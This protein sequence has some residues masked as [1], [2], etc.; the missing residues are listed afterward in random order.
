MFS[1]TNF[2]RNAGDAG[3][4]GGG[5]VLKPEG[6]KPAGGD[7]LDAL[8]ESW[9][10]EI[11]RLRI[12]AADKRIKLTQFEAAQADAERKRQEDE[13]KRLVEQGEWKTVA[14]RQGTELEALK[15]KAALADEFLADIIATNSARVGKLSEAAK[16]LVPE[17]MEPRALSKWLDAAA[18]LLNKP[19]APGLD[20]GRS[21]TRNPDK[22]DAKTALTRK[23]F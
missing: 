15:L 14:E 6:D 16:K 19:E 11:K 5:E 2:K 7:G 12:E 4:N 18:E 8:P 13:Q 17:G 3:G 1:A 10:Q 22:L 9:Q 23:P 21:G 20:G